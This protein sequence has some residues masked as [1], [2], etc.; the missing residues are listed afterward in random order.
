[1]KIPGPDHPIDI[2]ANPNRVVV[3]RGDQTIADTHKALRLREANYRAVNYIPREDVDM[4]QLSLSSHSTHCPFKGDASYFGLD[5]A[6]LE[7]VIWSYESPHEA[8]AKIAGYLAFYPNQFQII[9]HA[10]AGR[11]SG[12][13]S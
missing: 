7:N 1:M 6:G 12:A 4:A 13:G 5:S 3:R 11:R 9:E 2:D 10:P 8:V